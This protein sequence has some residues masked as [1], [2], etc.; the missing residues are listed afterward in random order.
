MDMDRPAPGPKVTGSVGSSKK[1]D[2]VGAPMT[3]PAHTVPTTGEKYYARAHFLTANVFIIA[4]TAVFAFAA[5]Y[6]PDHYGPIPNYLKQIQNNFSHFLRHNSVFPLAEKGE[7]GANLAGAA[8]STTITMWGGNLFAP[9]LK[10][11]ENHKEKIVSYF[12]RNF[13]KPGEVEQGHERL[14]DTPKQNW[15]DIL[16]GRLGGW[17]IV[18]ASFMTMDTLLGRSN[19]TGMRRFEQY[20]EWFGRKI[21]GLS[22]TGKEI[23]RLPLTEKLTP[24]QD[25]HPFYRF[26]KIAALDFYATSAAILIW[27]AIRLCGHSFKP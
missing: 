27:E 8:A 22:Q 25:A 17:C 20:E 12:N 21:A 7:F 2:T 3:T 4:I 15:G 16:K 10:T 18:F 14:K 24:L 5:R 9:L 6:G 13:G 23:A 19:K 26:G 11:F 1:I